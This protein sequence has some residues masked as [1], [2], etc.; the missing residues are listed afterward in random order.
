MSLQEQRTEVQQQI[1]L[2][3]RLFAAMGWGEMGDGHIS[4]RDPVQ[5]DTFWILNSSTPF[6]KADVNDLVLVDGRGKVLEGNGDPS[7]PAYF[8]HYPILNTR[9]DITS[10]AHT[11]TSWGTPFSA[12]VRGFEAIT[13]E[14][15]VFMDDHAIFDDETV[16]IQ[17]LESGYRIAKALQSNR[18]LILRNHGLL[19]VGRSVAESITWFVM[20]EKV[21]EAHMKASD[22]IPISHNAALY[23]KADLVSDGQVDHAFSNLVSHYLD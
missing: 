12:E 22:A 20:M 9:Q 18:G 19:T 15:C 3:Y 2:G 13:Q 17:D 11:H 6:R 14:S 7:L 1:V 16:Q 5:S 10:V 23:A 4:G 8:I 21:A